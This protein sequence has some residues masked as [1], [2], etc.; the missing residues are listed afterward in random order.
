MTKLEVLHK[1]YQDVTERFSDEDILEN[2]CPGFYIKGEVDINRRTAKQKNYT[3]IGCR[4]ITCEQCW[5]Q[6]AKL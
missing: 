4:G 6:E 3:V 5:N 1:M 2:F